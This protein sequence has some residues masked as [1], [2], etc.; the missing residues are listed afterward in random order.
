MRTNVGPDCLNKVS[1]IGKFSHDSAGFL[2]DQTMN[3]FMSRTILICRNI[4]QLSEP[5]AHPDVSIVSYELGPNPII[6][7]HTDPVNGKEFHFVPIFESLTK[8]SNKL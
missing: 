3:D 7:P 5:P 6:Q 8:E 2:T 1:S 4:S